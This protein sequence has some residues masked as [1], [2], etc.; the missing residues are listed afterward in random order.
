MEAIDDVNEKFMTV[1]MEI[2]L[3]AMEAIASSGGDKM[4]TDRWM[5]AWRSVH[6]APAISA[7]K[8]AIKQDFDNARDACYSD[9]GWDPFVIHDGGDAAIVGITATANPEL[10]LFLRS[11][12]TNKAVVHARTM[13]PDDVCFIGADYSAKMQVDALAAFCARYGTPTAG[14]SHGR[15]AI[16]HERP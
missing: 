13:N 7:I 12:Y 15:I 3:D 2:A 5:G 10:E 11:F 1:T 8:A 16:D 9:E 6:A 14:T 4:V